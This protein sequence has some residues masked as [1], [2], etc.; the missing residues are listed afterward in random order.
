MVETCLAV[1]STGT[2]CVEMGATNHVCN[3]LQGFRE[4]R[5]LSD[6]EIY[7]NMGNATKVAAGSLS[8]WNLT[9]HW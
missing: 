9:H 4:T 1:L 6:G 2:C 8:K 3:S 7:L 5:Q